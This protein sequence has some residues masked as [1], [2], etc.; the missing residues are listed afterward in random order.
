MSLLNDM[1]HDLAKKKPL[2][3]ARPSLAASFAQPKPKNLKW[4]VSGAITCTFLLLVSVMVT[5]HS[6]GKADKIPEHL[7]EETM[8]SLDQEKHSLPARK[9]SIQPMSKEAYNAQMKKALEGT[10]PTYLNEDKTAVQK[11]ITKEPSNTKAR[12]QLAT[13]YLTEKNFNKAIAVVNDGLEY[14]PDNPELF[15]IKAK[16]FI[17]QEQFKQA[18]DLLKSDHP[19]IVDHPEFYATLGSALAL[20]GNIA[21]AG[22]Y[23]KSLIK[24]DPNN[25]RYW[26][27]Y[28]LSLEQA[29]Q[30]AEA[31][32]A[33]KRA[34]KNKV[35]G[36]S[37]R[38]LATLH[39]NTMHG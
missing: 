27:G 24:V 18:I 34:S 2:E 33:Y 9:V 37:V 30:Y 35:S 28:G 20:S 23:F 17:A 13:I 3:Q 6:S 4:Y 19:S 32:I 1:L 36:V 5:H 16:V 15:T 31:K 8:K 22:T 10:N 25:G 14:A 29:K 12:E 7:D 39:L 26:L 21:E 11:I 38:K